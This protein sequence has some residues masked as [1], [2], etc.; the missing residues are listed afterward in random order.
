M[1]DI[2][3]PAINGNPLLLEVPDI[4]ALTVSSFTAV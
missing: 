3:K 4:T 1:F 2:Q